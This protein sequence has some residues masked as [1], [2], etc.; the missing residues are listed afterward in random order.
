MRKLL[1]L[2]AAGA[3]LSLANAANAT[4]IFYNVVENG[5]SIGSGSGAVNTGVVSFS[6]AD[7]AGNFTVNGNVSGTPKLTSPN[8]SSNNFTTTTA[9]VGGTLSILVTETGLTSFTGNLLNTFT[10][11]SLT[12]PNFATATVTNYFDSSNTAFGMGTTLASA[13]F[14]GNASFSNQA[15]ATAAF[16]TPFSETTVY[17][18][19]FNTG[20]GGSMSA[21]AQLVA[22]P[23]P[24]SIAL[25]GTGLA[26]VGLIRRKRA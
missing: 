10:L 5:M 16:V 17:T 6:A 14:A 2:G 8:F 21:S 18:F 3:V 13:T 4:Q 15:A 1:M 26:A 24:F 25:L 23:E 7:G 20:T 12:A 19:T 11:N 9:G 22:T